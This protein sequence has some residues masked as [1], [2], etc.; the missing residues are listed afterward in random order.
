[1]FTIPM[2]G[3]SCMKSINPIKT[4]MKSEEH[5]LSS[6]L[7]AQIA[8]LAIQINAPHKCYNASDNCLS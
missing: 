3:A 8:T 4:V 2:F 1:M 6:F 7:L 5:I